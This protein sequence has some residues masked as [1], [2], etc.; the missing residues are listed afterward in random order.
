M[1]LCALIA[2]A[3]RNA[4]LNKRIISKLFSLFS[5]NLNRKRVMEGISNTI[6]SSGVSLFSIIK[7][8]NGSGRI[9]VPVSAGSSVILSLKHIS[10][11][12]VSGERS[13]RGFSVSKLRAL[14]NLIDLLTRAGKLKDKDIPETKQLDSEKADRLISGYLKELNMVVSSNNAYRPALDTKGL[15]VNGLI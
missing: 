5:E 1:L 2:R 4:V 15:F 14:D 9:S 11:I 6:H 7:A 3:A 10:T 12:P 8:T 13:S